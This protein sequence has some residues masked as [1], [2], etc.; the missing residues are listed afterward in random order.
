MKEKKAVQRIIEVQA[1]RPQERIAELFKRTQ[2]IWLG[3]Q[4]G[5]SSGWIGG[6]EA[7]ED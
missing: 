6:D 4:E 1:K 7:G 2:Q 5:Q 3:A